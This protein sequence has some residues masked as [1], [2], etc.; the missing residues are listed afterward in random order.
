MYEYVI[1]RT[2]VLYLRVYR[3]IYIKTYKTRYRFWRYTFVLKLSFQMF[4]IVLLFVYSA[5]Y[6][7]YA[8]Y[9]LSLTF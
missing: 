1:C 8:M 2:Y 6:L 4:N 3:L 5:D 9:M 7:Y